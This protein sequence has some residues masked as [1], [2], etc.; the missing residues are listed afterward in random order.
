MVQFHRILRGRDRS[1][2]MEHAGIA[3][4][5]LVALLLPVLSIAQ[6]IS[7]E[8]DFD[9]RLARADSLFLR[10]EAAPAA[11]ILDSLLLESRRGRPREDELKVL[12]AQARLNGFI[13][14]PAPG[15][16]S[17]AAALKI[18][19]S[20]QDTLATCQALRWLA[21]AAQLEGE[22]PEART[23]AQRM[24]DLA[25]V[26]GDRTHEA[27]GT[28]FLGYD[29][30]MA[31]NL[32]EASREY[33]KAA[34]L[35]A[36]TGD[37]R[38]EL[39]ARTGL[40]RAL[41]ARGE[42]DSARVCYQYVLHGSR[43]LGDPFGEAHALNNLG[44]LEFTFGDP[45]VAQ[46]LYQQAFDLQLNNGNPEGGIGPATNLAMT[47]TYMGEFED[48]IAILSKALHICE[49]SGY[50]GQEALVL[51][52]M[53]LVRK[54]QG[55]LDEA[56]ALLRRSAA[57]AARTSPEPAGQAIV[58]LAL[59]VALRDS[60]DAALAILR[61]RF[62]PVRSLMSQGSVF[63][64]E[65]TYGELLIRSGRPLEALERFRRADRIGRRLGLGFRV[66]PLTYA[67]RCQ[68]LLGRPDSAGAYL[69]RAVE[70]WESERARTQDPT[71][72][73][74]LKIDGRL[75]YTELGR[76]LLPDTA[77]TF[78]G[79]GPHSA[80]DA[81]QRFKAR[82]LQER[83]RGV[84][85]RDR[86]PVAPEV[87][88]HLT[89][90]EM[91]QHC[92]ESDELLLDYFLGNDGICLLGVTRGDYRASRIPCDMA[93]LQRSLERYRGLVS[94]RPSGVPSNEETMLLE[95]ASRQ[96]SSL[97]L[98]PVADLLETHTRIILALDGFLNMIPVESLPLPT[99][100]GAPVS[101]EPLS[102][103][104]QV[105]RI[106]S[107]TLLKEERF[108]AAAMKQ[109]AR[110]ARIL[111]ILGVADSAQPALPGAYR[112]IAWLRRSFREVR[113]QNADELQAAAEWARNLSRCDILHLASHVRIDDRHPWH[114]GVGQLQA[115]QI[116]ELR[117]PTRLAV[118]A[119]CES[120]G[121]RVVSGEGVL[122]LTGAF[123]A[124]G[125]P[126][127]IATLWPVSDQITE[128]LMR[129]F[130]S[131]LAKGVPVG[132]A[133]R[134]SQMTIRSDPRT[135]HPFYWAGFILVGE[136]RAVIPIER[137]RI[138]RAA[139]LLLIVLAAVMATLG[140]AFWKRG[141]LSP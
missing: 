109:I 25:R 5:G 33:T 129:V 28:L 133:L 98:S 101:K 136:D 16:A 65:R 9:D 88:V 18:A 12:L 6:P 47:F 141:R 102:A 19:A 46:D 17:A 90:E 80:F 13:G 52:Q 81:L 21:L 79:E 22:L 110:P 83:M 38:F 89:L 87:P 74:Q 15:R 14:R 131:S 86:E 128:R 73:E 78:L 3:V 29:D 94:N 127:V 119:G 57:L 61:N 20:L 140:R 139:A 106:P 36:E 82:T 2:G 66:G 60:V 23:H 44:A 53:G 42:I 100:E 116:A 104:R 24:L 39:M 55:R 45:S 4:W 112:E 49:E 121:G 120:G 108:Q 50:R 95:A 118:L 67:A 134:A 8:L 59:T 113:I 96:L 99:A 122:G 91:Q 76:Q 77:S 126:S 32:A 10:R 62:E 30:L 105:V 31:G 63:N 56:A 115:R 68:A 107:A 135:S 111:A 26:R 97:F 130:Y 40:G 132:E 34:N 41:N 137:E 75:L 58:S 72:R 84:F 103:H 114:S 71:W 48:A 64:A 93:L 43:K 70:E 69:H 138:S 54:E 92:L 117:L 37:L 27:H 125:V 85:S 11:A 1:P 35:F 51:E 124:A 123:M 7:N